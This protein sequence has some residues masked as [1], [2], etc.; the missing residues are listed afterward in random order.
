MKFG[1]KF[2]LIL[3][4]E[5]IS[6]KLFAVHQHSVISPA[7]WVGFPCFLFCL[8]LS[9]ERLSMFL[10]PSCLVQRC[11]NVAF[12][13]LQSGYSLSEWLSMFLV[14]SCLVQRVKDVA[15][16]HLQSGYSPCERQSMFLVLSCLF[17]RFKDVA[18]P[19][20]QSVYSPSEWLSMF[21]VFSCLVQRFK[22][23]AFSHLLSGY[24]LSEWLSMFLVPSCL[25]QRFK[26]NA[27][28][29]LKSGY[30]PSEFSVLL[31]KFCDFGINESSYTIN[32]RF[33]TKL[34]FCCDIWPTCFL[35]GST[36][37]KFAGK[38]QVQ[39]SLKN[40]YSIFYSFSFLKVI[41]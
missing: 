18:F 4:R 8:V 40:L 12:S 6:R 38:K 24:S 35:N 28:L 9:S 27:F 20:L 30:L 34:F 29:H 16:P 19:H 5:Y 14:L 41:L 37:L 1:N 21:L 32:D 22:D 23:V 7:Q 2:W 25:V 36:V 10:V 26:D 39:T 17:L 31:P 13:H 33:C 15:Y 3:F 11:K